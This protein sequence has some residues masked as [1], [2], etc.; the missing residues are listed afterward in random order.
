[1]SRIRTLKPEILEDAI[2][3]RFSHLAY[4]IFTSMILLADDH[5]RLRAEPTWLRAQILWALDD[6]LDA[7]EAAMRE[8]AEIVRFYEV[9]GQKYAEIVGWAK[10]QKV[11]HPGKPRIPPPRCNDATSCDDSR[12]AFAKASRGF[13]R[14][15]RGPREG[16]APDHRSPI[17]DPI[18]DRDPPLRVVKTK[19]TEA[20]EVHAHYRATLARHRPTR[21]ITRL[22]EKDRT[23]I[24]KL[25]EDGLTVGLLERAIDGLFRSPHHLGQN[26]DGA[27][28]LELEYALRRPQVLASMVEDDAG[29][30]ASCEQPEPE[31]VDPSRIDDCIAAAAGAR[32]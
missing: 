12:E 25:L 18:T 3:A 13:A 8:I 24:G 16:L 27:E 15:S 21:E 23:T 5:G 1:M 19:H 9:N 26:P 30:P 29:P 17:T 11:D 22:S 2:T 31:Y 28:Y 7:V 6:S 32:K 4:R 10:H 14:P 20:D